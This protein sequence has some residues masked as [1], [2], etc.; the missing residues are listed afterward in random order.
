MEYLIFE[1]AIY[2]CTSYVKAG[3]ALADENFW[4][5]FDG[6]GSSIRDRQIFFDQ[7]GHQTMYAYIEN[8][9]FS[10]KFF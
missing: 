3:V 7:V 10:N 4:F 8:K 2:G 1:D 6:I 9:I 5:Y